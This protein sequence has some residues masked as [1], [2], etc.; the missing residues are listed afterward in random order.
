MS[1]LSLLP[2]IEGL[3]NARSQ[4]DRADWLV[5]CPLHIL[6][7]YDFTIRNRLDVAGFLGAGDYLDA[8]WVARS[9]LRDPVGTFT[10]ETDRLLVAAA[11]KLWQQAWVLDQDA[12]QPPPD[13]SVTDV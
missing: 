8:V 7:K 9:A 10:P 11:N 4:R 2:I 13:H 3:A 6:A 1:D 12:A 5:R